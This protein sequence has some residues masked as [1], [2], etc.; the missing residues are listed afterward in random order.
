[1]KMRF[2]VYHDDSCLDYWGVREL[3]KP[4]SK[5]NKR[6]HTVQG[7]RETTLEAYLWPSFWVW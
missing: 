5:W 2:T 3:G 4:D 6:D 1:M 7:T